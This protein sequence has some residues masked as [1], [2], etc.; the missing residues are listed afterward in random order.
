MVEVYS[1]REL[2]E[3][4][5]KEIGMVL[6]FEVAAEDSQSLLSL[7]REME[8]LLD[9]LVPW[10]QIHWHWEALGLSIFTSHATVCICLSLVVWLRKL[11]P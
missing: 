1:S 9:P 3:G 8:H 10:L 5:G 6:P 2:R 4:E 7:T 11:Y